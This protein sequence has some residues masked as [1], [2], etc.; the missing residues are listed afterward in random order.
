MPRTPSSN[1]AANLTVS[2][3][4]GRVGD[5]DETRTLADVV[6]DR[7]GSE[8]VQ[9]TVRPGTLLREVDIA[10]RLGVSRSPVREAIRRLAAEGLVQIIRRRVIVAPISGRD[11]LD[12]YRVRGV[13]EGLCVR[14]ILEEGPGGIVTALEAILRQ[15]ES[16]AKSG[17]I[18]TYHELNARFHLTLHG[19]CPNSTIRDLIAQLWRK[20][21]RYRLILAQEP[22]RVQQS[23]KA[24][25]ELMGALRSGDALTAE[26]VM[27]EMTE[28]AGIEI[29]RI[30]ERKL[31]QSARTRQRE[32]T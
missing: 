14:L 2:L 6:A 22:G 1:S 31:K 8:I 15:M 20:T 18:V 24:H 11:A 21:L 27:R 10:Q 4:Y 23:L 5:A 7:L 26:K 30:M 28:R 19:A 32:L 16:A 13:L 29:S 25:K 3:V 9:G 17:D 12:L